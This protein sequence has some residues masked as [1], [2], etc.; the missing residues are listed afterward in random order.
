MTTASPKPND[1]IPRGGKPVVPWNEADP[2]EPEVIVVADP[3]HVAGEAAERFVEQAIAAVERRGRADIA[4][5]GG[6]SA[7]PLLRRVAEPSVRERIAWDRIHLWWGDDRYVPRDHPLSNVFA[8]DE[9]LLDLAGRSGMSGDGAAA[10]D[11]EFAR[12][13]APAAGL[14]RPAPVVARDQVH[15][16]P[17]TVAIGERRGAEW[18]ANTYAAQVVSSVPLR[19]GWPA[20]DIV[21]VGIGEDGHVLSVFPNS[22]A[23]TSDRIALAVPAPTH[24]APHVPRV[25]LNPAILVAAGR[26]IVLV[27]GPSKAEVVEQILGGP[28][29]PVA[30]PAAIARRVTATWILDE[31][32]AGRLGDR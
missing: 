16:F 29:D 24:I 20:F 4:L 23:L 9:I 7:P 12:D 8:A 26:V 27:S 1:V 10:S 13:P 17:T 31:A 11:H 28:R 32:A 18:C 14:V 30:L 15:P 3:E 5:T 6:S 19:D 22:E 21:F 25:T 2:G